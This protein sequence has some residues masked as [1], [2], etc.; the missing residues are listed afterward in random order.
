M[1]LSRVHSH[2]IKNFLVVAIII[3]IIIS[4]PETYLLLIWRLGRPRFH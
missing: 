2:S 3:I 1:N 4:N